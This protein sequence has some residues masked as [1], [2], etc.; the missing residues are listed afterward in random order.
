MKW[1]WWAI[2]IALI[3]VVIAGGAYLRWEF[4]SGIL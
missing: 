4:W 1:F 2:L 3:L